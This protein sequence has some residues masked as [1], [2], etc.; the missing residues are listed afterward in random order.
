MNLKLLLLCDEV[1]ELINL[2]GKQPAFLRKLRRALQAEEDIRSVL[3]STIRLWTLAEQPAD[4]SPFLSGFTP[5]LYINRLEDDEARDLIV[6]ANMGHGLLDFSE[7]AVET[8][9]SRCDNH[10]YLIQLVCKRTLELDDL[11][12]ALEQVGSDQMVSY[13]FSADFEM[14]SRLERRILRIISEQSSAASI[15]IQDRFSLDADSAA[16]SLQRLSDL[17]FI[18]RAGQNRFILANEFFRRWMRY[19]PDRSSE[20]LSSPAAA[21]LG[22]LPLS[23]AYSDIRWSGHRSSSDE[24]PA[25]GREREQTSE[26]FDQRYELVRRIGKGATGVVFKAFDRVLKVHIAMKILKEDYAANE[27]AV[28]RMRLEIILSRDISHPN[29]LRIYDLGQFQGKKYITMQWVE[30]ETLAA[31]IDRDGPVPEETLLS[32]AKKL[33]SALEAAHERKILHRDL[34]PRNVLIDGMVEPYIADFGLA[35][36]LGE[37]GITRDGMFV[38][39]PEYASPEQANLLPLDER[40]DI[41]ALG[42]I[43]FEMAAGRRP[44][45]SSDTREILELHRKVTPPDPRDFQ[46]RITAGLS[47]LILLCLEKDRQKRWANARSLREGLESI[48]T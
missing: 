38:G 48:A 7:Q 12:E 22:P 29:I 35:R 8:I 9:R 2:S 43:L 25:L 31:L 41:Y 5:P 10:P 39:T 42:L 16:S 28:E 4:T 17:G 21:Q 37:P 19:L 24:T 34:K 30:G 26:L 47:R 45:I 32:I 33:A 27:S 46:P 3:A 13:F 11:E 20:S 14:L 18:R 6:Q 40:S 15:S 1:E 44:F 36:L 23:P